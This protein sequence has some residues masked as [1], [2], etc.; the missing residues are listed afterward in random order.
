MQIQVHVHLWS[1][2]CIGH[3]KDKEVY[4]LC[5][6]RKARAARAQ[7][8]TMWQQAT[9]EI[10]RC[11]H[12]IFAC[13]HHIYMGV[14]YFTPWPSPAGGQWCPAPHLNSVPLHFM[15]GPPNYHEAVELLW[16][17]VDSQ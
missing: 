4:F 11:A 16:A 15:F 6:D 2:S 8:F 1:F 9:I 13:S 10:S 12:F 5:C 3:V 14:L 7:S 17:V